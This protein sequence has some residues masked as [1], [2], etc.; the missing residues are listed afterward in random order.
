MKNLGAAIL[1]T[2]GAIFGPSLA[3]ALDVKVDTA[4]A[5]AVLKALANP[6]LTEAEALSVAKLDGNEGLIR[7]QKSYALTVT[8][9]V[10]AKALVAAA[11]GQAVD[12][13]AAKS[14]AFDDVKSK[15]AG[16]GKLLDRIDASPDFRK[17][18][19]DRVTQFTPAGKT[20]EVEGYLIAGG[21]SGG[22]AFGEPKFYLNLAYVSEF[23]IAKIIMAHE[24]Y[25][26]VQGALQSPDEK[27]LDDFDSANFTG[28]ADAR[29]C[30]ETHSLFSN[31]YA[32]GTASYVGDILLLA[33]GSGAFGDKSLQD[34]KD[35]M[36]RLRA[37]ATLLDLSVIGLNAATP[38]KYDDVYALDF[39]TPEILY[40]LGYTMA[41]AIAAA[42]GAS[43][44]ASFTEQSSYAFA[45][46]YAQLP[47]Y[48]K[49]ADHPALGANTLAAIARLKAGCK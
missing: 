27:T 48:G 41:R 14:L 38:A 36:K 6:A 11:H 31:L 30:I 21:Q 26:A 42:D 12:D 28:T 20:I 2:A 32:E 18:V 39:Y 35:G 16:I 4:S 25:H 33:P 24:L 15:S 43:G 22:F 46:R 37:S 8:E 44:L 19:I 7:K 49:D 3:H 29:K 1:L 47:L 17:W 10:F 45:E 40:K 9:D 13:R 34:F 23:E 5:R